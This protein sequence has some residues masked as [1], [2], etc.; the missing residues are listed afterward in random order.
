M[1]LTR[2]PLTQEEWD[3]TYIANKWREDRVAYYPTGE[4]WGNAWDKKESGDSSDWDALL[5]RR[6]KVKEKYAKDAP[7]PPADQDEKYGP[8]LTTDPIEEENDSE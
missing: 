1:E 8:I 2:R 5:E 7:Y 3:E 6:Q 4:E